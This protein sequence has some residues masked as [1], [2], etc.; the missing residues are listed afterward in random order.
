MICKAPAIFELN[1][2]AMGSGNPSAAKKVKPHA[3]GL[4]IHAL[5]QAPQSAM[6]LANGLT[7]RHELIEACLT[8]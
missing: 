4:M 3:M 6:A 8:A 2:W 5:P 7:G 1:S